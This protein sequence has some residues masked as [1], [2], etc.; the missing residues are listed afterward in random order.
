MK[1]YFR[2]LTSEDIPAIKD[3]SKDIWEGEDYI[4]YVIDKWLQDE[5]CMNYGTFIDKQKTDLIGFGRVKLYNKDIAWLEGGRIKVSYQGQGIGK[6]QLGY[7]VEYAA[8][9]GVKVAQY[10]TGS[11]NSASISLAKFYGFKKKKCLDL[12]MANSDDI[13]LSKKIT[14]KIEYL[15]AND[16]KEIYR[17]IDIGP[18]EEVCIGWSFIPLNYLTDEHGSWIYNKE[19][20]LQKVVFGRSHDYEL[21]SE[22]EVWMIVYGKPKAAQDLIQ[23]TIEKELETKE[24]KSFEV[25]CKPGVVDLIKDLGFKYWDDKRFG[26]IL[27]EKTFN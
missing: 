13:T 19:A 6:L 2:E 20:I 1:V 9:S 8:K 24:S 14:S 17:G 27:F 7:A 25:F 10:D 23:I 12:M 18:G 16:V 4:P 22:Q 5:N 11:D 21:P 3:I 15:T 26:V